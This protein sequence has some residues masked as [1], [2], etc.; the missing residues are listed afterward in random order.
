MINDPAIKVFII[1]QH[2]AVRRALG[3]RLNVSPNLE[4]VGTVESSDA[5]PALVDE[6]RPDVVILGLQ[7]GDDRTMFQIARAVHKLSL[8]TA[9]IVLAPFAD[10]IER[11]VYLNAGARRYLLKHIDSLRLIREITAVTN[12]I[13]N[14]DA[15]IGLDAVV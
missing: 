1:E 5:A 6:L 15:I 8:T 10:E 12:G 9:V 11:Q 4:V 7:R 3:I 13:V 14:H 2:T